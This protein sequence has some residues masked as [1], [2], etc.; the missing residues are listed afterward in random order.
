MS[1]NDPSFE[2]MR[3]I[4]AVNR[5]SCARAL[6]DWRRDHPSQALMSFACDMAAV[7]ATGTYAFY[8]LNGGGGVLPGALS[9]AQWLL[10]DFR[11]LHLVLALLLLLLAVAKAVFGR[12]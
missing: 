1:R 2:G 12:R 7:A 8:A 4:L 9:A 10:D 6:S 5:A 3:D 11:S